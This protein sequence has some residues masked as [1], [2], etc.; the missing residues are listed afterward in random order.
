[1]PTPVEDR[2]PPITPQLAVR[3][4]L[5]GGFAFVLFAIVFFRLWFLQ[6]L[7]GEDYV[8][9]ARE[10]RVR[11]VRIEAPRGDIV[12]RDGRVLVKTRTRRSCRSC[13]ARCRTRCVAEAET[14]ARRA[15]WPRRPALAAADQLHALE[16]DIQDDKHGPTK[17]QRRERRRLSRAARQARAVPIPPTAR[18]R[19]R[20]APPVP[21]PRPRHPTSSPNRIH[22]RVIEGVA[23]APY[24][25]VTIRT[26]DHR[27]A[28]STTCASARS[29]SRASWSRS[30]TC[31]TTRT[32]ELAAQ[33]FGTTREISPKEL[34][35]KRYQGR[36]GRA[37]G[38]AQSGLEESY[39]KY[40][41]GKDG[42][43]RIVIDA[44][45]TRDDRRQAVARRAARRASG[46]GSR[47]TSTSSAPATDA[48][49][50]RRSRP[51][52]NGA[53]GRRVRGDGPAQRRGPGA[54]A[55]ARASTPTC[56]PSRSRRSATTR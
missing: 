8:A 21:P 44:L 15:A 22:E 14:S 26:D 17:A 48:L 36:R 24:S 35:E 45:G 16:R 1:M 52:E 9:K 10:N 54:W 12:D 42:Y 41:R 23:D 47:S 2:R 18:R 38:S 39:D 3:V 56:S 51:R 7:S 49:A 28:S 11:K 46:C 13:R 19:A 25:N 32:S 5:L 29:S 33:L 31:A 30:S 55:R 34:K 37:R 43:T 4:A 50:A 6:V 53:Q 27:A 20:A 40:L